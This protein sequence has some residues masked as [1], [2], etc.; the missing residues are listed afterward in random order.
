MS[1]RM[2]RK[3]MKMIIVGILTVLILISLCACGNKT[4]DVDTQALA[5]EL[6]KN[7]AFDGE[8]QSVSAEKLGYYFEIPE[9]TDI[10]GYMSNGAT[11][12]EIIVA[13][14]GDAAAAKAL[15]TGISTYMQDQKTEMEKY[16]PEEVARLD[17]AI[18]ECHKNC[19]VLCVTSYVDNAKTIIDSYWSD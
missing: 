6:Q 8:M 13:R 2:G 10:Y 3:D 5:D 9:G 19:V 12:E 18:L 16:M 1:K 17:R 7:V 15:E 4:V 14:C 11:A